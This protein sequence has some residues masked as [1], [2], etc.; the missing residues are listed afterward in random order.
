MLQ[1]KDQENKNMFMS[2]LLMIHKTVL[3]EISLAN[4]KDDIV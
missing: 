2:E 4:K 3:I 1:N